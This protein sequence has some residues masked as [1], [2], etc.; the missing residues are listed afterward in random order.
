MLVTCPECGAKISEWADP[1]PKC[2]C[3]NAGYNS[4]EVRRKEIEY[5]KKEEAEGIEELKSYYSYPSYVLSQFFNGSGS[6]IACNKCGHTYYKVVDIISEPGA[7]GARRFQ[8]VFKLRCLKC[9]EEREYRI[10]SDDPPYLRP[11]DR[12]QD[13]KA[14]IRKIILLLCGTLLVIALYFFLQY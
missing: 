6:R 7:F 8:P 9:G 12:T 3:P 11:R 5:R 2:G 1:C 4:P 14:A 13:R 10:S